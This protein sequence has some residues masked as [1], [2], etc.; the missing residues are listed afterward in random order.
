MLTG[1]LS[2]ILGAAGGVF[3]LVT[4]M[5]FFVT[6]VPG[7]GPRIAALARI[8]ARAGELADGCS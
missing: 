8:E 1:A 2:T 5:F 7:F 3:F 6:A 4:V